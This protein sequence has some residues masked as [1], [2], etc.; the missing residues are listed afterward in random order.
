MGL[1]L[2]ARCSSTECWLPLPSSRTSVTGRDEAGWPE[3]IVHHCRLPRSAGDPAP[4]HG[5]GAESYAELPEQ[6][7]HS[8]VDVVDDASHRLDVLPGGIRSER[9]SLSGTIRRH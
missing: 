5:A 3:V 7:A 2:R 6:L 9:C 8:A 4:S 1:F